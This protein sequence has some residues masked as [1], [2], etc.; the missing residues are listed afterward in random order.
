MYPL[1]RENGYRVDTQ[2]SPNLHI[3]R[4]AQQGSWITTTTTT[5]GAT[6]SFCYQSMSGRTA[7][8]GSFG[9]E[10]TFLP[11]SIQAPSGPP[12]NVE[13]GRFSLDIPKII[14]L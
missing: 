11:G 2:M 4:G 10:L 14:I 6:S 1:L 3:S 8:G 5:S 12:F 7:P 9:G 13:V